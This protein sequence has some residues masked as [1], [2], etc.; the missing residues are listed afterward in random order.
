MKNP[1]L[2]VWHSSY[3]SKMWT[4][5]VIMFVTVTCIPKIQTQPSPSYLEHNLLVFKNK[6]KKQFLKMTPIFYPFRA[7]NKNYLSKLFLE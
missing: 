6:N 1:S 3:S 4:T 7:R 5:C 2:Y